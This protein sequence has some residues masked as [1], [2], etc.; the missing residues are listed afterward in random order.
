MFGLG[1]EFSFKRL[2]T[3]G[4]T[5]LFAGPFEALLMLA[6]G[7]VGGKIGGLSTINSI[8]LGGMLSIS[9]TAMIV[10]TLAEMDLKHEPFAKTIFGVL[11]VEDLVGVLILV[12]LTTFAHHSLASGILSLFGSALKLFTVVGAWVLVGSLTIPRFLNRFAQGSGDEPLTLVS[13]GLCLGLVV[14]STRFDYSSALGAFVMGSI[15]GES[16]EYHRID[17]LIAPM[18]NVFGAVFFVSI[19]MLLNPKD[20]AAHWLEVICVSLLTV[21]GKIFSTT[22]GVRLTGKSTNESLQV[23][24][25]LAQTGEFSF[26]I[27]GLGLSL[28]VMDPSLYSIAVSVS[29]ITTFAT[30]YLIRASRHFSVKNPLQKRAA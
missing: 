29:V 17:R 2:A 18:R 21:V 16:R 3:V 22:L 7:F 19:G 1:L 13:L 14:F 9:S 30:P 12:A 4:K 20:L 26:I 27:A 24:M 10:K 23:G 15:I 6:I 28:G 25:A 5:A 11:V 8:F